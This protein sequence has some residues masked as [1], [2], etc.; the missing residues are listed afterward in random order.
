MNTKQLLGLA[1]LAGLGF[2]L[3]NRSKKRDPNARSVAQITNPDGTTSVV[4]AWYQVPAVLTDA[5]GRTTEVPHSRPDVYANPYQY[6]PGVFVGPAN[7]YS[8]N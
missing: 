5:E 4:P 1:A 6:P 7:P 3:W 2:Y 8:M